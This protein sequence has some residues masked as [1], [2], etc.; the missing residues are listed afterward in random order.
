MAIDPSTKITDFI[1]IPFGLNH[2]S[3]SMLEKVFGVLTITGI[4]ADTQPGCRPVRMIPQVKGL[5]KDS[6]CFPGQAHTA[7]VVLNQENDKFIF[8]FILLQAI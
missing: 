3:V 4:Q 2:G 8:H 7:R 1:M 5:R 6:Q